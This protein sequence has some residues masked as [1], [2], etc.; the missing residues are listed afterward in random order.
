MRSPQEELASV[1]YQAYA[2]GAQLLNLTPQQRKKLIQTIAE[3]ARQQKDQVLEANTLDLVASR[4][5]AVPEVV[6][7]WSK[8]TPERWQQVIDYLQQLAELPDLLSYDQQESLRRVP[9]GTVAF[10]YEGFSQLALL[11]AA[12]CLKT[13][14]SILIKGGTESSHTQMAIAKV[15][16]YALQQQGLSEYIV[17]TTPSGCGIKELLSQDKYIRLLIPYGRPSFVQ[18]LCKQA[19]VSILPT[20]IGNCY[21]YVAPS[22]SL[23]RA[24]QLI[25]ASR[26]HQP[27]PITAI[28][29]VIVHSHWLER[30]AGE[31]FIEWVRTLQNSGL[32]VRGCEITTAQWRQYHSLSGQELPSESNWGQAFLDH[33]LAIKIVD[34]TAEAISWINQYSS[35]HAD[36]ALTDCVSEVH[37]IIS[38]LQSSTIT[39]NN[40]YQFRR[41][42]QGSNQV[43]LGMSSLKTRGAYCHTGVID[44]NTFTA[45]KFITTYAL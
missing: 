1:V 44:L 21:M 39:I 14:N 34:S 27:D 42:G 9:L 16:R 8:L 3:V 32:E 20:A 18:Q 7:E 13:G 25:L 15:L 29:K 11:S 28:E 5:M 35:G 45:N 30:D 23:E 12:M 2:D 37:Q 36:C 38:R 17:A 4:E 10:V 6:L 26:Q 41:G 24:R 33:S 31:T 43:L 19:T 22:G 40:C